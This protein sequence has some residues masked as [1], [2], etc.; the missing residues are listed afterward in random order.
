MI[1]YST[2]KTKIEA[3]KQLVKTLSVFYF[4]NIAEREVELISEIIINGGFN[5]NIRNSFT[6]N[7][8]ASKQQYYQLVY[9]GIRIQKIRLFYRTRFNR[10]NK[11]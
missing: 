9:S 7:Y 4:K 6:I 10:K 3:I 5:R 2:N 11:F 1:K 8:M